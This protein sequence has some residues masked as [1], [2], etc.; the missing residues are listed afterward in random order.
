MRRT[1]HFALA[2]VLLADIAH[3]QQ[4]AQQPPPPTFRSDVALITSDVVVRD[5][6]GQFQANLSKN[7]FELFEDGVK[8]EIASFVLVHGGRVYQSP[9]VAGS[10]VR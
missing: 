2:A 8:Q 4:P 5:R 3:A 6:R 1:L 9:G 7:D 10:A